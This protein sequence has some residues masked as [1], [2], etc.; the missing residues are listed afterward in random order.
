M[1]LNDTVVQSSLTLSG[2]V[3]RQ[4]IPPSVSVVAH[5]INNNIVIRVGNRLVTPRIS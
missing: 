3:N 4:N 5:N 1:N 2:D